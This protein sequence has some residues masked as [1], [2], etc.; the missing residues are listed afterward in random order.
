[1]SNSNSSN[2]V[3]P[4]TA[5]LMEKLSATQP[6]IFRQLQSGV[7]E[8]R[9]VELVHTAKIASLISND[10]LIKPNNV[11]VEAISSFNNGIINKDLFT[12]FDEVGVLY[13]FS[14]NDD[15]RETIQFSNLVQDPFA[16][17]VT[18]STANSSSYELPKQRI[19]VAFQNS[20]IQII[21]G[22]QKVYEA[23]LSSHLVNNNRLQE[24]GQAYVKTTTP[25]MIIPEVA[26]A[27]NY[28]AVPT[29][30]VPVGY[31]YIRILIR[32]V[33]VVNKV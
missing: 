3:A 28:R 1:M 27:I 4:V 24:A 2:F 15:A 29:G 25:K 12:A 6:E 18:N 10:E 26:V 30:V 16:V 17:N 19:P 21:N 31:H 23:A 20:F 33:Q 13:G 14:A 11:A 7:K 5:Y 8:I 32:G 22:N 9:H